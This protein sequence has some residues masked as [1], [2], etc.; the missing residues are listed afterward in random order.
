VFQA[1]IIARHILVCIFIQEKLHLVFSL[2]F[3]L[4]VIVPVTGGKRGIKTT[5]IATWT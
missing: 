4:P 5:V 1:E 3:F 2:S